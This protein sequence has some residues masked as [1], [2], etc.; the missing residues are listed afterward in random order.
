[1][2]IAGLDVSAQALPFVAGEFHTAFL[3]AMPG[4]VPDKDACLHE[5]GQV[6]RSG[7]VMG[8]AETRRYSD[9]ISL[10]KL[11]ALADSSGFTF[12]GLHGSRWQ[13]VVRF[14]RLSDLNTTIVR[15]LAPASV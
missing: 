10:S 14:T 13:D 12:S 9:F 5:V 3:A 11:R 15:M 7:G 2:L 8:I 4:E 6:L 1:V